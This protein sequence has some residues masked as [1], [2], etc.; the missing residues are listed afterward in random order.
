MISR[1]A[2]P[3]L[4]LVQLIAFAVAAQQ[5]AEYGRATGGELMLTPKGSAPFSGT[6]E[7]SLSTGNG[8]F[9]RGS[10]PAYGLTAGGTLMQDRLWFFASGSRQTGS[11]FA[12]REL[13]ENATSRSIGAR[14]NG[15]FGS[16]H[17][18]SAFFDS[19]R[20]PELSTIGTSSFAGSVPSSFLSLHYTGIV[21]SNMFFTGSVTSSSR[22]A[23]VYGIASP[24]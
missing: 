16:N 3:A 17:D 9:G 13:P 20:R 15:Q 1:R 21:S 18:F 4:L 24:E 11:R 5:S 2:V 6:L 19:A 12:A 22:R 7:L 8:A 10:S 14:V 23:P